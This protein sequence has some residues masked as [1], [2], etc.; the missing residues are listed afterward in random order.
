MRVSPHRVLAYTKRKWESYVSIAVYNF[1]HRNCS[2]TYLKC[3]CIKT[4][5]RSP[6]PS[7]LHRWSPNCLF[8]SRKHNSEYVTPPIDDLL[9]LA[10]QS[11]L[12][13]KLSKSL[14]KDKLE[15]P[16]C[17][18]QPRSPPVSGSPAPSR[19]P[20]NT[21]RPERSP[22]QPRRALPMLGPQQTRPRHRETAHSLRPG[23]VTSHT[24]LRP[25]TSWTKATK[26]IKTRARARARVRVK[27]RLV[28]NSNSNNS[29]SSSTTIL[30]ATSPLRRR[31]RE[32]VAAAAENRCLGTYP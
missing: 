20:F 25:S 14:K 3:P 17:L 4:L 28:S 15:P 24:T 19:P 12:A 30:A 21:H 13:F 2:G 22:A 10:S 7:L 29:Y 8:G 32:V 23:P 5:P 9:S 27:V 26:V 1:S 11:T 31:T 6:L 18:T 16:R